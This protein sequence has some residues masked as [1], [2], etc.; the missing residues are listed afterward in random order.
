MKKIY[1]PF[2]ALILIGTTIKAQTTA[3]D[4]TMNDCNGK[5]HHLF[6]E[7]DS[8][9]VVIME[10]F[11][12]SCTPCIVAGNALEAM[13]PHLKNS[14]GNKVR[15]YHFGF[16]N[17]Y[18][19]PQITNWVSTNGYTSVPFDSGGVQVAYYGGM[20][21]PTIAVVAGSSHQV[22]WLTDQNIAFATSDTTI[23][24]NAISHFLD[25]VL[26]NVPNKPSIISNISTYPNPASDKL[27]ISL[28][29]EKT[30][31]LRLSLMS[32]EGKKIVELSNENIRT[33]SWSKTLPIP[34]LESGLYFL[35]GEMNE[36]S[37]T[38]K[39]TIQQNK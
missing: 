19:C 12:L 32:I 7:L 24:S 30:G 20:G 6:N 27:S 33:G 37:F 16:T 34:E 26:A 4:F 17:S 23:I 28:N 13:L 21:M 10:F 29:T 38:R 15:F 11:M 1:T 9:N 39:I 25:S 14:Y 2:L 18:T 5:M 22:L 8:Q 3:M 36:E 35:R 31:I